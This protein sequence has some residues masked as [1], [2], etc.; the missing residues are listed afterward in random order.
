[1]S[2][3]PLPKIHLPEPVYIS[4]REVARLLGITVRS[5]YTHAK[6][7]H[8]PCLHLWKNPRRQ[9]FRFERDAILNYLKRSRIGT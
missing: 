6:A 7:G 5:V 4:A 9:A 8:I 3:Q 2:R 1:V